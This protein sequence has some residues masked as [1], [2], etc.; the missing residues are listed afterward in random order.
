[1]RIG[2]MARSYDEK[3]GIGVYTRNII[4]EL[5]AIDSQNEYFIY[6]K[7]LALC[8]SFS[9]CPNVTERYVRGKFKLYWDQ[10]AIPRATRRD[11]VVLIFHPKFTTPLFTR[12]KRIMVVHGADTMLPEFA[13]EYRRFDV[14]NH[15]LL[16]PLYFRACAKVIST[17]HFSTE[18]FVRSL[19]R[20][21]DRLVTIYYGPHPGFK[22]QPDQAKLESIRRRYDLPESFILS[23]IRYDPGTPNTRKNAGN[24]LK[25]FALLKKNYGLPHKFVIVGK[26]CHRYATEHRIDQLGIADD[27]I[28]PGL[29]NQRDLPGFYNLA[30]LLLHPSIIAAFPVPVAEAMACGTPI[31]TSHGTGLEEIAGDAALKVNPLHPEEIAKAA[32]RLIT[33]PRLVRDLIQRG[34]AR[35]KLFRWEKCARQILNVFDQ[36]AGMKNTPVHE[37][38]ITG[39]HALP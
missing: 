15:R 24:M 35:S 25:A 12:A 29:V 33:D 34:F 13:K 11:G 14:W 4:R 5:L 28:F 26:E 18:G 21:R 27:V 2:I 16:R 7:N 1:M 9:D 19:P 20:Y 32:H 36:V 31:V 22:P 23:V 39:A 8:G 38:A 10:I 17:S 30:A 3:G 37:H 6:Y